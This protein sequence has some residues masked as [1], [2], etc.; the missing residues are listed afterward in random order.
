MLPQKPQ[1]VMD[2]SWLIAR[3]GPAGAGL[4]DLAGLAMHAELMFLKSTS[5]T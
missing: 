5:T 3:D 2:A 4:S 1:P